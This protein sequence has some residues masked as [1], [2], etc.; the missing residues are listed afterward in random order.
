MAGKGWVVSHDSSP[1]MQFQSGELNTCFS[2]MGCDAFEQ[3]KLDCIGENG[4]N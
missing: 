4:P 1:E 2:C 3:D